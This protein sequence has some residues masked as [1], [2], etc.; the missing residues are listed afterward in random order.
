V[1]FESIRKGASVERLLTATAVLAEVLRA[2][3]WLILMSGLSISGWTGI[4]LSFLSALIIVAA[5]TILLSIALKRGL[6]LAEVRIATL[7][8]GVFIILLL[9]RLENGGGAALWDPGWFDYAAGR[10]VQL[11]ASFGFGLFLM[12]RGIA[13]SREELRTD[14]LYRSFAV[15]V[16]S[17]VL[18]MVVWVASQGVDAGRSIF[19][20]IAPY[21]LGYFFTALMGIGISNFLS[22]RRGLGGRPKATDLFA[23]RWLL[24]LFGIVFGIVIV[25]GIIAS[26]L[27]LNL[28]ALIL[29]PLNTVAGWLG[30]ALLYVVGYPL[31]YLVE[32]LTW[33]GQLIVNWLTSLIN[34]KPFESPEFGDFADNANKLQTGQV[35]AGIFTVIKWTVF[36]VILAVVIYFLSRAIYRY[37]RGNEDKGYEEINESLWSWAGFSGDLKAFLKGL[38]DRFRRSGAHAAPPLAS[39]ITELQFLDVRELYRG[40]LWEGD[41]AGHPKPYSQTPFEYA[42]NLKGT[43]GGEGSSL[44]AITDAYV[45]DRYGHLKTTGEEGMAL[46]RLWLSL[47][48]ALRGAQERG[49]PE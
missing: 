43:V 42:V 8:L 11:V 7:S 27:S 49:A 9:T 48:A 46:V 4:P 36:V 16:A 44:A 35:P 23:R 26:G 12:W 34:A 14:F 5:V 33:I 38:T 15:G 3:P 30:I 13:I 29:Q 41:R 21:I 19:G 39:T 28:V 31:G 1:R 37:W 32:G 6:H 22:L 17:F 47:R 45:K 25:A 2:Y 24:L 10:I 40:L 18:L 20:T